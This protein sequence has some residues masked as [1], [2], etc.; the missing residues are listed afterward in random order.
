MELSQKYFST[1]M[2][3]MKQICSQAGTGQDKITG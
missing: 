3:Q 1:Q 2:M